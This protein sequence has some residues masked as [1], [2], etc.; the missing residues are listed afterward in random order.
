MHSSRKS[1]RGL[2]EPVY[3]TPH[4]SQEQE[5]LMDKFL[6][7][8]KP[9]K[10]TTF[11]EDSVPTATRPQTP[12]TQQSL[13]RRASLISLLKQPA[14]KRASVRYAA[15]PRLSL[16]SV[17]E[18]GEAESLQNEPAIEPRI[19]ASVAVNNIPRASINSLEPIKCRICL[20]ENSENP[21]EMLISPCRCKG[22]MGLLHSS[23][24]QQWLI[25]AKT[26]KCELCG[27]AYILQNPFSRQGNSIKKHVSAFKLWMSS[28]IARRNIISDVVCTAIL[29]VSTVIIVFLCIRATIYFHHKVNPLSWQIF[30]LL[31]LA[32]TMI[33]GMIVWTAV[34]SKHHWD[35]YKL[36]RRE[37]RKMIRLQAQ[38][39]LVTELKE[40]VILPRPRGSSQ[41]IRHPE[42]VKATRF[43]EV[44]EPVTEVT[45]L[46]IS[47]ISDTEEQEKEKKE[48]ICCSPTHHTKHN[49]S[50]RSTDIIL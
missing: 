41:L 39:D 18:P 2:P 42:T 5:Q 14:H 36:A 16:A 43:H 32:V 11:L 38:N 19:F 23:C 17:E 27:Y 49:I 34:T 22:T 3:D 47:R 9:T 12:Q 20:S 50:L 26:K 4:N 46:S 37:R 7:A 33:I 30:G 25:T 44:L 40:C 15:A 13:G 35:K 28:R 6:R 29:L 1:N 24:L 31:A 45:E 48:D 21:D 8:P 10:K